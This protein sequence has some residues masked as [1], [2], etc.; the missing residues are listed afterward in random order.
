MTEWAALRDAYGAATDVPALLEAAT[1]SG[2]EFGDAWDD[3]WSHLCHQGTVYSASYAAI[4]AL[5][6]TCG[7]HEPSGY[8]AALHLAASILAST[9]GPEDPAVV[10]DRYREELAELHSIAERGLALAADD[11]EFIYGLETLMA[12]ENG[13][14]WQRNLS[15]LADGEAPLDCAACG[16]SLLLHLEEIPASVSTWEPSDTRTP[17]TPAQPQPGTVEARLLGI[18]EAHARHAV[19][20]KL[21]YLFGTATCP[22]C[23]AIIDISE[24]I[25]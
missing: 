16:T 17:A 18:A 14:V 24:S 9:D 12:F 3:V 5:A 19:I 7:K 22:T 4:P 6:D 13:G 20:A 1:S 11:T 8:M 10:R 2:T 15:C 25:E 23:S 21:P